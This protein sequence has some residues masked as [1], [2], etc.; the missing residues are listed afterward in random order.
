MPPPHSP[1]KPFPSHAGK[2]V[3][4]IVVALDVCCL[5]GTALKVLH[6]TM[7][8]N[9]SLYSIGHGRKTQKEFLTEL[10]SFA[11]QYLVDVRSTPYSK[12]AAHFNQGLIEQWLKQEKIRYLYMGNSLGGHP[13]D[14]A[15]CQQ[16]HC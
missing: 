2:T 11:I 5:K 6:Y 15:C 7:P 4:V 16:P 10:K 8:I 13:S 1:F 9:S 12:W 3:K 14:D